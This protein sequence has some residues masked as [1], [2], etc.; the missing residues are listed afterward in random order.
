MP[1]IKENDIK[2][3]IRDNTVSG[4]YYICGTETYQIERT[5][6]SIIKSVAGNDANDFNLQKFAG[7]GID[8][9][10]VCDAICSV[11]FFADKKCIVIND[12]D[13]AS[14]GAADFEL[15]KN[16]IKSIPET[17]VLVIYITG[18]TVSP[19]K[20]KKNAQNKFITA[21]SKSGAKVLEILAKR[22]D[23]LA[24]DIQRDAEA[25]GY[26]IARADARYLAELTLCNQMMISNE[27]K[28]IYAYASDKMITKNV[29]D[30]L[31]TKQV[32]VSAFNLVNAIINDNK[33]RAFSIV[34]D[35]FTQKTD[36]TLITTAMSTS[37]LDLYH[38]KI[39]YD[40]GRNPENIVEDYSCYQRKFAIENMYK[41]ARGINI[42][43]VYEC[44][45]L[46]KQADEDYKTRKFQKREY[47]ETMIMNMFEA[48]KRYK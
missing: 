24:G 11:P 44:L 17:T 28:K 9:S 25:G 1:S 33:T 15:L 29:I 20:D 14:L 19:T 37:L 45:N 27:L 10:K 43:F 30:K 35:L 42:K 21:I 13:F 3:A 38:A 23:E 5:A 32:S 39:G 12:I 34:D 46:M 31:V 40:C 22:S 47:L 8:I 7:K 4:V 26:R 36:I 6:K 2:S 16:N 41:M 18:F 48:K